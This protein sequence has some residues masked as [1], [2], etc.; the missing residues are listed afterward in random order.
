[1][2]HMSREIYDKIEELAHLIADSEEFKTMRLARKASAEDAQ[3]FPQGIDSPVLFKEKQVVRQVFEPGQAEDASV[4]VAFQAEKENLRV[5]ADGGAE[6]GRCGR[7]DPLPVKK[8]PAEKD[9]C[10]L[11]CGGK[12]YQPQERGQQLTSPQGG[13][14]RGKT[15]LHTGI[16]MQIRAVND[17]EHNR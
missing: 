10:C 17:L 7:G 9:G 5:P 14:V 13:P 4:M 15:G 12:F 11:F 2:F 8:I 16:Q 3:A 6:S 1:M